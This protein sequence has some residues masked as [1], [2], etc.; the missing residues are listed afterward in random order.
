[1][2]YILGIWLIAPKLNCDWLTRIIGFTCWK[3]KSTICGQLWN[4]RLRAA[5]LTLQ[6]AL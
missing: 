6:S 4:G 3:R 5:M 2:L 1:M